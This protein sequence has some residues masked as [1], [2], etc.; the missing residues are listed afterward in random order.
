[1][2]TYHPYVYVWDFLPFNSM[3]YPLSFILYVTFA[4]SRLPPLTRGA[5][6]L[7][8]GPPKS[9]PS[10]APLI[11]PRARSLLHHWQF[12]Q[13]QCQFGCQLDER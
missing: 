8:F 3:T 7:Q 13:R 11:L 10:P 5:R 12:Q 9:T 1:M 2:L 4:F 6:K